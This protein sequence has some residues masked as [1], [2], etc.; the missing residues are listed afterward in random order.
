MS[1]IEV[2]KYINSLDK[3]TLVK[4][5]MDLYSAH[6][7]IKDI[8]EYTIHPN[9]NAKLEEYKA[10]IKQ[11]FYP[12]RGYGKMRFSVCRKDLIDYYVVVNCVFF[13]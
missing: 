9:D 5:I 8:L 7:E 10:I 13:L 3:N 12:K 4:L 6:K 2:K 1:K 11:E